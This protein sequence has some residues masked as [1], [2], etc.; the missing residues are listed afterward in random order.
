MQLQIDLTGTQQLTD[1]LER[2]GSRAANTKHLHE[3]AATV[4]LE[5]T[6]DNFSSESWMGKPWAPWSA[7]THARRSGGKKLQ[8]SGHLAGSI[9]SVAT[10]SEASIGT[11]LVYAAIH[12]FGGRAGRGR[13][14]VIPARPFLPIEEGALAG[15]VE[16]TIIDEMVGYLEG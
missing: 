15:K 5:T 3:I 16:D 12:Q 11:N 7:A 10:A 6:E 9:T 13:R 14:S 2:L 1:A 4:V 8:D